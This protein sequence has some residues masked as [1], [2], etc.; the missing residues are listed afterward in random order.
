MRLRARAAGGLL[1]ASLLSCHSG[2]AA[3]PGARPDSPPAESPP[4]ESPAGSTRQ[5]RLN[6][7]AYYPA[8][9]KTATVVDAGATSFVVLTADG[10]D[11]VF[12]GALSAPERW[13][14]SGEMVRR[15]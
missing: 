7:L 6:Q 2:P 12:T 4:G 5:I 13:A 14:P 3:S 10:R 15:A 9:S 1:L 11:T 8:A